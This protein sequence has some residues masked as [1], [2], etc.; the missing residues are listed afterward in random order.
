M[1][2][3]VFF[4]PGAMAKGGSGTILG[5]FASFPGQ[6]WEWWP[7]VPSACQTGLA[8]SAP[9]LSGEEMPGCF[10]LLKWDKA[11]TH[12]HDDEVPEDVDVPEIAKAK[13]CREEPAQHHSP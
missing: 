11:G 9:T 4:S 10:P 6:I 1:P 8:V 13:E 2:V 7:G 12:L 3:W 5:V